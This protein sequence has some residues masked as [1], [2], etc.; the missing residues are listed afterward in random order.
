MFQNPVQILVENDHNFEASQK[1]TYVL[2]WNGFPRYLE[3]TTQLQSEN[4]WI[5]K[6]IWWYLSSQTLNLHYNFE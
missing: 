1:L 2:F 6:T 4:D 3:N 5:L